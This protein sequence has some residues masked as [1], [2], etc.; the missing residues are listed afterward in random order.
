MQHAGRLLALEEGNPPFELDKD[1]SSLGSYTYDDK[2]PGP[3]TAHPKVDPATGE[4][5]FFC[6]GLGGMGSQAMGYYVADAAGNLTTVEQF[7]SPYPAMVH[8]FVTPENYVLFPIFPATISIK[9]AMQGGA[10]IAWDSDCPSYIGVL[11]RGAP[12]RS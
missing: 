2:L 4:M 7:D 12:G 3:M 6:Y 11:K 5:H 9:R 1:L 10:P 8:D